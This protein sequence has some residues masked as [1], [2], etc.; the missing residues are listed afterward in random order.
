MPCRGKQ[1]LGSCIAVSAALLPQQLQD[2][3]QG[4]SLAGKDQPTPILITH[5]SKDADLPR[6]SV[7]LT[8]Q[9][10]K[11]AGEVT[12][13][14]EHGEDEQSKQYAV[15]CMKEAWTFLEPMIPL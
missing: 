2:L 8:V 5:G 7:D 6:Q 9:A 4:K 3:S 11:Q 14:H 12:H 1:Q 13:V 15:F 10:A